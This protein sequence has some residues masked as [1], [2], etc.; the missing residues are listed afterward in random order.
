MVIANKE[1][2]AQGAIQTLMD[3][4]QARLSLLS[5]IVDSEDAIIAKT[6]QGVVTSLNPAAERMFGYRAEEVV[7]RP[8]SF[9]EGP[10]RQG[11]MA[12]ILEKI[13]NG[14]HVGSYESQ[15]RRKDG[16]SIFISLTVSPIYDPK[17][18]LIGVSSINRDITER[19]VAE[20]R[21]RHV[22]ETADDGILILGRPRCHVA[23][24]PRDL[25]LCPLVFRDV[26][27]VALDQFPAVDRI[28]A[29]DEFHVYSPAIPG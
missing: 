15:R 29:T 1:K 9:L 26:P 16:S 11:E 2:K 23:F 20:I 10:E 22:F 25:L 13:G 3:A 7:G 5:S 18:Q 12:E 4:R 14:E 24:Q 17:G 8:I 19:K 21:Y 27:E 28:H 6:P